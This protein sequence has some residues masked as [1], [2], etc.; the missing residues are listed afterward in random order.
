MTLLFG[1]DS[2]RS[3]AAVDAELAMRMPL[4]AVSPL[5]AM[6]AATAGAGVAFWW[7]TRWM[8][9]VNLEALMGG[10]TAALPA[11]QRLSEDEIPQPPIGGEAGPLQEAALVVAAASE[12]LEALAEAVAEV[13]SP[14]PP[15]EIEVAPAL[16]EDAAPAPA[17][18]SSS[19]PRPSSAPR[20]I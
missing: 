19:K 7:M 20:K 1:D 15:P 6:Y 13:F 5:W 17:K 9:P 2:R 10:L 12:P 11:S 16:R 4:G 18:P 8:R 14:E 3:A